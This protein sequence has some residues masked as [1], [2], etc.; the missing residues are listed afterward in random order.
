M[1]S[2]ARNGL[3]E[4]WEC[5]AGLLSAKLSITHNFCPDDGAQ[6]DISQA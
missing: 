6:L 4:F 5:R 1:S 2:P 3:R